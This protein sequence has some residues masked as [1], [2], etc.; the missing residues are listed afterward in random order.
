LEALASNEHVD[1][2]VIWGGKNHAVCND[3]CQIVAG[4]EPWLNITR[5][6]LDNLY[7][8]YGSEVK[9]TG[10]QLFN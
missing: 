4:K 2:F 7:G 1:G 3:A 6:Y 5:I 8:I 9:E 10:A